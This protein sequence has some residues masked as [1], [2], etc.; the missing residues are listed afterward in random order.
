MEV[1]GT[2]NRS[3]NVFTDIFLSFYIII[4]GGTFMT[5]YWNQS[6]KKSIVKIVVDGGNSK[7]LAGEYGP[8]YQTILNGVK[9]SKKSFTWRWI[10]GIQ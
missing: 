2:E 4:Y 6:F 10:I 3:Y 1:S 7:D 9:K 5:K 8:R